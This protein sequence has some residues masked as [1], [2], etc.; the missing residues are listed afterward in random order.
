MNKLIAVSLI[1]IP[2]SG[3]TCLARKLI[4]MSKM[5][6]LNASVIVVTFDDFIKLDFSDLTT[7]EYKQSR[8]QLLQKTENLIKMLRD[9]DETSWSDK[10]TSSA[11]QLEDRNFNVVSGQPALIILDDNMHYRSMRQR[12]RLVCRNL[13]CEHFQ[14]F[15]KCQV[16]DAIRL[17]MKRSS[18]VPEPVIRKMSHILE[19]PHNSRTMDLTFESLDETILEMINDQINNSEEL[20][21]TALLSSPQQQSIL[22]EIDLIT[23]KALS[24]RIKALKSSEDISSICERLNGKRKEFL[25]NLRTQSLSSTDAESISA[26]FQQ[27]LDK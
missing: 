24:A 12:I 22:H 15:M 9:S 19:E 18:P 7:G 3:K 5:Q 23:R 16:D 10:L 25:E 26:A 11:L 14:I 1:G 20:E 21:Q 8:E 6:Q 17:N 2:A 27:Y 4:Q 13:N